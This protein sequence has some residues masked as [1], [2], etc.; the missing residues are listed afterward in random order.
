M[1]YFHVD[2]AMVFERGFEGGKI[3]FC[4]LLQLGKTELNPNVNLLEKHMYC[5]RISPDVNQVVDVHDVFKYDTRELCTDVMAVESVLQKDIWMGLS[6]AYSSVSDVHNSFNLFQVFECDAE[7]GAYVIFGVG[8]MPMMNRSSERSFDDRWYTLTRDSI[9]QIDAP[10]SSKG[11]N[12]TTL[13]RKPVWRDIH[14][15]V[16][17]LSPTN[18]ATL[19]ATCETNKLGI[20]LHRGELS[21]DEYK[22]KVKELYGEP[23]FLMMPDPAYLAYLSEMSEMVPIESRYKM[24]ISADE[25]REMERLSRKVLA[26]RMYGQDLD[27]PEVD[28]SM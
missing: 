13:L 15:N 7:K 3:G 9:F 1:K 19:K 18:A 26:K 23:Y 6:S 2:H 12:F 14:D 4:G 5:L 17:S 11:E 27:G 16:F 20:Q 10:I 21:L 8:D 28:P 25:S 24:M 22:E